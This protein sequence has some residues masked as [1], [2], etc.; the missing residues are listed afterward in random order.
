MYGCGPRTIAAEGSD[1][2]NPVLKQSA[3]R[4]QMQVGRRSTAAVGLHLCQ[5]NWLQVMAH[6]L[7][8]RA[9]AH[10]SLCKPMCVSFTPPE[11]IKGLGAIF[12]P[13]GISLLV[14]AHPAI[15]LRRYFLQTQ[16]CPKLLQLLLIHA[17]DKMDGHGALA[18]QH[19]VGGPAQVA[20]VRPR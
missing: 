6:A 3:K 16:P 1:A 17:P 12:V 10:R 18:Q 9:C 4:L 20:Q 13:R 2:P 15:S 5:T 8:W 11:H 14:F 19:P 7:L